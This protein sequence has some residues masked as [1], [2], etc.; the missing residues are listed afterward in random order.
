M[1]KRS[2]DA[3]TQL[4]ELLGEIDVYT[5]PDLRKN[6]SEAVETG[7]PNLIINLEGVRYIDSSGLSVLLEMHKRVR[8]KSGKMSVI[9]T[10]SQ[11]LKLFNLTG[12][13]KILRVYSTEAEA[14]EAAT[15][16]A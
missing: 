1:N 12:L 13:I 6:L 2:V 8:G 9:C 11:I 4:V 5:A 15:T 3:N 7:P 14:L 10:H 16:Q